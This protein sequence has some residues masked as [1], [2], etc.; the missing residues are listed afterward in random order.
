MKAD[1][2]CLRMTSN[3]SEMIYAREMYSE[4]AQ[5]FSFPSCF[6]GG[7]NALNDMLTDLTWLEFKHIELTIVNSNLLCTLLQYSGP[8]ARQHAREGNRFANMVQAADPGDHALQAHAVAR[9]RHAAHP[10]QV[11]IPVEGL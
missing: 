8:H 7:M 3:A 4:F 10:P 1:Q 6:G 9:V 11:Q 5:A 2:G